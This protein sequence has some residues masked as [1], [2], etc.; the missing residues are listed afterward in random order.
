MPVVAEEVQK[1][2]QPVPEEKPVSSVLPQVPK[3]TPQKAPAVSVF[4]EIAPEP[5]VADTE[6]ILSTGTFLRNIQN[7][8]PIL[9]S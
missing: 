3:G 6:T 2:E 1:V 5:V 4:P 8:S 9:E 7:L